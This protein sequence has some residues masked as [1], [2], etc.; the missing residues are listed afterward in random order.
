MKRLTHKAL[1]YYQFESLQQPDLIHGVFTRQGGV[2]TGYYA[3]LNLS[4]STGDSVETVRENRRRM[5]ET[6]DVTI[7]STI[8]SWLVHGKDVRVITHD[9]FAEPNKDDVHADAMITQM[10]GITLTMRYAD[11]VPILFFD[12]RE[13][14]VGIAHAGWKGIANNVISETVRAMQAQF[15]CVPSD[16]IGCVG[17]AISAKHYEV[18]EDV[19]QQVQAA[20]AENVIVRDGDSNQKPRLDLWRAAESQLKSCGVG[21]IEVAGL[22]TASNLDEWFSHRAERGKTGRFGVAIGLR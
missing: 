8:T 6:L 18:S 20:V 2:S 5:F 12:P 16:V 10:R 14:V 19:A 11:C 13:Q 1:A 7:E 4:R 22:C 9:S 15:G 17:P 3:S 21:T